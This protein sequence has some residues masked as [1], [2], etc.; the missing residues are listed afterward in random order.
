[1]GEFKGLWVYSENYDLMLELL[2]G[3]CTLIKNSNIELAAVLLGSGMKEKANEAFKYGADKVFLIDNPRLK[4][5]EIKTYLDALTG[6]VKSNK[7][8]ILLIGSTKNGKELASR[9][10][11]RLE[12]GCTPDCSQLTINED[13]WLVTKRIVYSGRAVVT[14]I[15][16]KKPQIAAVPPRIFE[17]ME[18][19]EKSGEIVNVEVTV[20]EPKLEVVGINKMKTADVKI[21]EAQIVVCGGRGIEKKEDFKSLEELAQLLKGQV[22]N[23]RPLAE[24]RKWFTG[25]I[26]LSGKKIKPTLYMGCGISGMIQHVAGMRDSQL[27]VAINKDPEAAIFEVADYV[28]VGDLYEIVPA[29]VEELKKKMKSV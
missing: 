15:F 26:G 24:D 21:E 17:K 11:A 28:V 6:L 10:A 25:W 8:E 2:A 9:L 22:G 18:P 29:I 12:T 14:A 27:V 7:P 20:E 13:G 23:T 4:N 5:F 19:K 16:R 1:M 3:S